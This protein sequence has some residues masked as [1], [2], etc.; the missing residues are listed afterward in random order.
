MI[1]WTRWGILSFVGFGIGVGIALGLGSLLGLPDRGLV[2]P[3]TIFAAAG[4]VNWAMAQWL[5][6]RL[7][8]PRPVTIT[9]MLPQPYTWPDGRVQTHEV[10]PACDPEGQP[11]WVTPSSSL[12][13]IPVKYLWIVLLVASAGFGIAAVVQSLG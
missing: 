12:F 1:I 6:P 8:R 3:T 2:V 7:D 13:F 4:A 11:L 5:Y 10:V 9:R